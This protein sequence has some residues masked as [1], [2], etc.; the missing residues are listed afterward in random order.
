[1]DYQKF[2][3][4][5]FFGQILPLGARYVGFGRIYG[6]VEGWA[7]GRGEEGQD[8]CEEAEGEVEGLGKVF[9]EK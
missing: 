8:G 3:Q 5:F 7:E 4:N 9:G 1:L 2:V 6:L